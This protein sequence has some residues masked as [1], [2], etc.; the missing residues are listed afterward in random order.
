MKQTDIRCDNHYWDSNRA[1]YYSKTWPG[2]HLEG[3]GMLQNCN[4]N[5]KT[6][7]WWTSTYWTSRPNRP[8]CHHNNEKN[9]N[10]EDNACNVDKRATSW[11]TAHAGT[12]QNGTQTELQTNCK[13][14]KGANP[15]RTT[16]GCPSQ[17]THL[18][19]PVDHRTTPPGPPYRWQKNMKTMVLL[20]TGHQSCYIH[21]QLHTGPNLPP[22]PVRPPECWM[23]WQWT[24]QHAGR[25]LTK[26][27]LPR[28]GCINL[29]TS[30]TPTDCLHKFH[31]QRNLDALQICDT[32]WD[33][34]GKGTNR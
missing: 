33:G 16:L 26:R 20:M 17:T 12:H 7:I 6:P 27:I 5:N 21:N 15:N 11:R 2:T 34:Q 22:I 23:G 9:D 30:Q 31:C 32:S 14:V 3:G 28:L 19:H 25:I 13:Q 10:T 1:N 8:T 4:N 18:R 29:N 24:G